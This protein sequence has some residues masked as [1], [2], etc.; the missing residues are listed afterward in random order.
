MFLLADDADHAVPF[1]VGVAVGRVNLLAEPVAIDRA[2]FLFTNSRELAAEP[3][4]IG[5]LKPEMTNRWACLGS[6]A[7]SSTHRILAAAESASPG[8][9]YT[10]RSIRRVFGRDTQSR[11]RLIGQRR[12]C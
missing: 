12:G 11:R 6:S 2:A 8:I 5:G 9:T 10:A 7:T 4:A 1:W 3:I